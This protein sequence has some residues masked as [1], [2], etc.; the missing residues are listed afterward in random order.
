MMKKGFL[1]LGIF[2]GFMG[3]VSIGQAVVDR[4][5][6]VVNQEVITLSEV[7]NR[8][9]LPPEERGNGDRLEKKH[10][11]QEFRRKALDQLIEERLIDQEATKAGIKISGKDV[12]AAVEEIRLRNNVAPEDM[13]RVLASEG[14]TLE[15]LK[16]QIE[17]RLQRMR[18]IQWATKVDPKTGEK[19]FL[20]FYQKNRERYR[21]AESYRTAHILFLVPKEASPDAIREIRKKAQTVLEKIKG[22]EDFAE[23]AILYSDDASA[24]DGGDLGYFKRGDLLPAF[25]KE[26]LRLQVGEVSGIVR[27]QF[28]FHIIKLSDHKSGML[29]FEEVKEKVQA[30]YFE[31]EMDAALK[32]Y[33]T[34]LKGKAIIEIK[35]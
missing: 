33:L 20:D 24:K 13:E 29:T 35:L 8:L 18:L 10:R 26:A 6:A 32:K 2:L 12:D 7:E 4:I 11:D 16:K 19:E 1:T 14:L 27:T 28:G 15:T 5:V 22:G 23:M 21:S 9:R 3:F 17:K 30:D 31:R 34:T 25:E